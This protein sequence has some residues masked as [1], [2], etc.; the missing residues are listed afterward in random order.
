M[1][2][3]LNKG[4]RIKD[5]Q[6]FLKSHGMTAEKIEKLGL[7][8]YRVNGYLAGFT[9]TKKVNGLKRIIATVEKFKEYEKEVK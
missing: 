6:D 7:V 5:N 3:K 4:I 9:V 2:T 8:E 1:Q